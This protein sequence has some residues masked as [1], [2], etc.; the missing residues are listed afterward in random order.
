MRVSLF[1]YR[2]N[3]ISIPRL[4]LN[5]IV[6]S[7][8][9]SVIGFFYCKYETISYQMINIIL[10][11]TPYSLCSYFIKMHLLVKLNSW[12]SLSDFYY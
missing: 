12:N 9:A 1:L 11:N 3:G 10:N 8:K 2:I 5:G 6:Y 4:N 7:Y